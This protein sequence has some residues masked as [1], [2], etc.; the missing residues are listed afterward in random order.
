MARQDN[1]FYMGNKNLPTV[2]WKGEYTKQQVKDLK[3]ASSNILYF[4]ENFFHII[5]LDRG[6]EKISL[7]KP[8]KRALRKMRDNRFFCLLA[9]RQIGKSTMMTIYILWQA[10]F[11]N[12]QR[13]LLVANKEATAIEI[14]QRVRM[15][16]EEL[17]NW[18][19]PP[20]KE[21]A[22]TSMTLENGSRIGITTTTGTA[23]RGQ[24]VNCLVID[25][26]AFIEPHLVEEFWKSVFPIITSSKKSKVFVCSTANGTDNLFYK[27]YIGAIEKTNSWAHDKI[28]WD[29]IPGRDKE[30]AQATKTALGSSE[31]WLQEFECEFIH[32]G[33]STL[34][35]EL[36]EEMMG[37]VSKPKISLDEGHY[38]IW[39]EPDDTKLY[40]AGV[41]ISEGVGIDAS[42]IQILD[43]TDIRDI[44]QVA[45]YRNNTIPPLEF[46]NRLYKILRNWGSPLALI[47]RNNCGAQVVDR[48]G[49]DLGYEKIVSYGNANAH[50][51]NVM[52]GMIAHTNTKYKGVLNMRYFMNEIRTVHINEEETVMELRNFVRY[53]NG[54]WKARPGFHDD[55]VMAILYSLFIL[56]KEI[57]ERFF[58]IV[59]LDDMGKPLVIEPMDFGVQYFEDPTSIYLD[60]EIV[61]SN[62][63]ALPAIV[64]GMGE[65]QNPDMDELEAFGFQLIG[66]KP[67]ENWTGEPAD[68]KRD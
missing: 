36:F 18:L 9:S 14:F 54:T 49:T 50:R 5:N 66:E 55:R 32:S 15:A 24:S 62:T 10:C 28:K 52:R 59:E 29:E 65:E 35:D 8:Q 20:V 22:K 7:Y 67:P 44:K 46:T 51:R 33:E 68:Y 11:N 58:E 53:P 17:P 26:M 39:E 64:W 38:K 19:K 27:L 1:M 23:A 45:V 2:N 31:A 42:V 3:K 56:E 43:I 48:L 13:I 47:E 4:A 57:T 21:Y 30:W 16:Y 34:D 37:K 12:D 40:A 6:K 25:E 63:H 41:D 60:E 61:G